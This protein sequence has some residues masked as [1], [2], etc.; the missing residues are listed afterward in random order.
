MHADGLSF[1]FYVQNYKV[2]DD[3]RIVTFRVLV[4]IKRSFLSFSQVHISVAIRKAFMLLVF[5]F[6]FIINFTYYSCL[7]VFRRKRAC[8]TATI[9]C[10]F[11]FLF[12]VCSSST[13]I[14]VLLLS[15]NIKKSN[16]DSFVATAVENMLKNII[17]YIAMCVYL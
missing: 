12:F 9:L 17:Q 4:D 16:F 8:I 11:C 14:Y 15:N 1:L 5:F 7:I 10:S 3:F 13:I 2:T 6:L